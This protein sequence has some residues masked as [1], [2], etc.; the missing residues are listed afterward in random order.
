[1]VVT[2]DA[3]Y[4]RHA[5]RTY[6]YVELSSKCKRVRVHSHTWIENTSGHASLD[7]KGYLVPER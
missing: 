5:A 7:Y 2:F 4:V 1:M 3:P 6:Q